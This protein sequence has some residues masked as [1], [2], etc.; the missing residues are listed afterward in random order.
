MRIGVVTP[1][2]EPAPMSRCRCALGMQPNP[3]SRLRIRCPEHDRRGFTVLDDVDDVA[4][5][6]QTTLK[7]FT[8]R[9][10]VLGDEN[11]HV[12]RSLLIETGGHEV[13]DR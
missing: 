10:V 1:S 12:E 9:A 5:F 7:D 4:R 8:K 11:S 13:M 6:L 2:F 3:R